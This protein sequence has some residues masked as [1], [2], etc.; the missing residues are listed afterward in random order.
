MQVNFVLLFFLLSDNF[1]HLDQDSDPLLD[2]DPYY[3]TTNADFAD[4]CD[5]IL[6]LNVKP[7][8]IVRIFSRLNFLFVYVR[9]I[10]LVVD[11][12]AFI[13][14]LESME[15]AVASFL[16]LCFVANMSYPKV[17]S[18]EKAVARFLHLCF[19]A[20]M[21]YPKVNRVFHDGEAAGSQRIS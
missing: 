13:V 15:K 5:L 18:M 20:N 21:S 7:F 6:P 8:Y 17:K 19:V 16:H 10:D 1:Y 3:C 12:K 9:Q 11:G 14:G 4:F 2:P